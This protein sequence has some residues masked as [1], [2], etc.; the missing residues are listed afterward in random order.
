[1]ALIKQ[2]PRTKNNREHPADCRPGHNVERVMTL[3]GLLLESL[4]HI[5]GV[6]A[7]NVKIGVCKPLLLRPPPN[8]ATPCT[9]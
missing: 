7:A 4:Q 8:P 5:G 2:G 3:T 6:D 9:A 1:M